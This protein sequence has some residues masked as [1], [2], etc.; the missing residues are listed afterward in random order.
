MLVRSKPY[1]ADLPGL[2]GICCARTQAVLVTV[3]VLW[4]HVHPKA[5]QSSH[6][7]VLSHWHFYL[8]HQRWV[9]LD[10]IRLSTHKAPIT[11]INL[12]VA[13]TQTF[14]SLRTHRALLLLALGHPAG[15]WQHAGWPPAAVPAPNAYR[16]GGKAMVRRERRP[17]ME[18]PPRWCSQSG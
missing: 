10:K 13:L 18:Q 1:K 16:D 12:Q 7:Q 15:C 4:H 2:F 14:G 9:K 11:L 5:S 17:G 8:P 3:C 6:M